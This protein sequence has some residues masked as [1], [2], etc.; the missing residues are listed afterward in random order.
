MINREFIQQAHTY[1][2]D[3]HL[4]NGWM[5]SEKLDGMRAF[6]DGGFTRGLLT[7]EVPFANSSK[8]YRRTSPAVSTGLWSRYAKAIAAP[9]WWLD[10]LPNFPLDGELYAGAGR[11]QFVMSTARR[12]VPDDSGWKEISYNCY[13][14]PSYSA[15]LVPGRI[16]NPQW[17]AIFED[18]RGI[19]PLTDRGPTTF[20]K[21]DRLIELGKLDLGTAHWVPQFKLPMNSAKAQNTIDWELKQIVFRGGEGLVLR[22][23][24]SVWEPYRSHNVLKVKPSHDSEATVMGYT[25]GKGKFEDMMGALK[26]SWEGKEFDL[27]GFTDKERVMLLRGYLD[28]RI[29]GSDTVDGTHNPNFPIGSTVTFK[30]RELSD[31]GIPKEARYWRNNDTC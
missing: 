30:Y 1:K 19:S 31:D 9:D 13:D 24:S 7:T 15:F 25:W 23:P 8:D 29:P 28:Y 2:P 20:H 12:F 16:N 26:V 10:T 17:T 4:V 18:M 22:K 21:L 27:S 3:K 14:I 11:F 6:W 5:L